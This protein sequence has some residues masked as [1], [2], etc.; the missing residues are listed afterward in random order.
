MHPGRCPLRRRPLQACSRC[1]A[2]RSFQ[3]PTRAVEN[4]R[5]PARSIRRHWTWQPLILSRRL[6]KP[7]NISTCSSKNS[8]QPESTWRAPARCA[9]NNTAAALATCK[10]APTGSARSD[11]YSVWPCC[12]CRAAVGRGRGQLQ[13]SR[14]PQSQVRSSLLALGNS[15]RLAPFSRGGADFTGPL[16]PRTTSRPAF[17]C[18]LYGREQTRPT[19]DFLRQAKKDSLQF[20]RLPHARRF[21]LCQQPVDKA[22]TS[23]PAY[24]KIIAT[25]CWSRKI[26]FS[27]SS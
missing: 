20:R 22:P 19:E 5:N 25:T 27:C 6:L 11:S 8:P 12:K 4:H 14:R 26:I 18:S 1:H 21:L 23:T 2:S 15:T 9:A 24:T 10:G 7:G 3:P 13:E 17:A 16:T